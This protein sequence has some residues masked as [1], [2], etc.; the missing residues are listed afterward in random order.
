MLDPVVP[1]ARTEASPDK[2]T[3]AA[4]AEMVARLE[5]AGHLRP[6]PARSGMPPSRC[7]G[8]F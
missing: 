3:N 6:G 4:R 8:R 5:A 1:P 7:G 2:G